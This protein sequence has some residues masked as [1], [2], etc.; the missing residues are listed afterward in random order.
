MW[1]GE[2]NFIKTTYGAGTG[3]GK[4]N[5]EEIVPAPLILGNEGAIFSFQGTFMKELW[6]GRKPLKEKDVS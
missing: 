1:P 6:G 5:E 3:K 4:G 2:W